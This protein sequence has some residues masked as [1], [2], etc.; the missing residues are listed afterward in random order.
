MTRKISPIKSLSGEIEIPGDKSLSHRGLIL[1]GIAQGIT[2]LENFLPSKDTLATEAC[3]RLLGV[4]IE[5]P[6]PAARIIH[7]KGLDGLKEPDNILNAENSGTTLRLLLGLL[8]GQPFFSVLTGD[9][10]LRKRPMKRV[11][12]PLSLMGGK[13][14]GRGNASLAPLCVQGGKLKEIKYRIPVASAQVKTAL[15]LAALQAEGETIL[16]ESAQTRDHTERLLSEMGGKIQFSDRK[17]SVNPSPLKGINL[18]IPGDFSS[19][20]FFLV[21]GLCVP[22]SKIT[23]KRV[24]LNPT[25]TAF[26]KLLQRMGGDIQVI[27]KTISAGNSFF[28]PE[29]DLVVSSSSLKAAEIF[30][31]EVPNLIDELPIFAIAASQAEGVSKVTHAEELRVKETDRIRDLC[32]ELRKMG[33]SIQELPDG[34][35]IEGPSRLKGAEVFSHGDHR[36]AMAFTIGGLTADKET[37]LN[38]SEVIDI[39]FPNFFKLLDK[40]Q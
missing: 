35:V 12:E 5:A 22:D 13:I 27:S 20:A 3:M 31:E 7:G 8:S 10:S 37:I 25:R 40:L 17:I 29:G 14:S 24:G 32:L 16:E 21:A 26:L 33:V 28:E 6:T 9:E 11:V 38:G 19:A 36:L 39:S 2:H 4:N 34:F 30:P 18:Y 15:I 23:L 1:G